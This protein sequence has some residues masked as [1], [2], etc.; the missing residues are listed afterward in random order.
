MG[1]AMRRRGRKQG[2]L[3]IGWGGGG[4]WW[5]SSDGLDGGQRGK[6]RMGGDFCE[7]IGW[8]EIDGVGVG[9]RIGLALLSDGVGA[10]LK[11]VQW[12]NF[13]RILMRGRLSCVGR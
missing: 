9:G 11:V 10:I 12:R 5:S 8:L 6:F 3:G 7:V 13:H 4:S 1:L 2:S